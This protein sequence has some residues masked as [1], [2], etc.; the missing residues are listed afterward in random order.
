MDKELQKYITMTFKQVW[1]DYNDNNTD[2][3]AN[4]I[5]FGVKECEETDFMDDKESKEY[6]NTW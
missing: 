4:T 5:E 6:F 3:I 1:I 2:A